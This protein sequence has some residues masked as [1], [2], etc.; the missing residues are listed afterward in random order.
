MQIEEVRNKFMSL[1]REGHEAVINEEE[2][3]E[4]AKKVDTVLAE[5]IDQAIQQERVRSI[6]KEFNQTAKDWLKK[7]VQKGIIKEWAIAG[8]D[9]FFVRFYTKNDIITL[10]SPIG[11][12]RS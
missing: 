1:V 2:V 7:Q 9:G 12:E 10:I 3:E 8:K 5:I 4:Y 11:E 6:K